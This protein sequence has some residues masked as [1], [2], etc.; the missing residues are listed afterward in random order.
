MSEDWLKGPRRATRWRHGLPFP[1]HRTIAEVDEDRRKRDQQRAK[2][3]R[4]RLRE[5]E[6]LNGKR[7][8]NI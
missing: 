6:K 1:N 4:E 3:M 5:R 7:P 8:P 2:L